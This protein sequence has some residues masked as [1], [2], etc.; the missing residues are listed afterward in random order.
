MAEIIVENKEQ[1][2]RLTLKAGAYVKPGDILGYSSGWVL[3]DASVAGIIP[4]QYIATEKGY[5]SGE[6]Q[7]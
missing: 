2:A 5:G 1:I 3:A 7:A 6:M 4:A